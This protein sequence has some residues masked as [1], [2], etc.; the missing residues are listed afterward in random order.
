[1]QFFNE[2][3]KIGDLANG[4]PLAAWGLCRRLDHACGVDANQA[5]SRA[6]VGFDDSGWAQHAED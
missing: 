5:E 4:T 6:S 1:M 3:A 2:I